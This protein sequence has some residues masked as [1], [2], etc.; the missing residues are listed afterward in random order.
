M[1]SHILRISIRRMM[2][3]VAM[4]SVFTACLVGSFR[5]VGWLPTPIEL[6]PRRDGRTQVTTSSDIVITDL[7]I[8]PEFDEVL[9]PSRRTRPSLA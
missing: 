9:G 6:A 1:R 4:A 7:I 8:D 2:A 3:V 5:S